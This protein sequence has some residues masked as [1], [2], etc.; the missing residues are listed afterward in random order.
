LEEG[1]PAWE[2][3]GVKVHSTG[4]VE[5]EDLAAVLAAFLG[6]ARKHDYVAINAY[7]PRNEAMSAALTE[8]RMKVLA[9]TGCATTVGFGPRFLHSTGQLHKGGPESGLFL[10]I[11][12]DPVEDVEIPGQGKAPG[13]GVTFG[14]LERCQ[15]L[16]DYEA[17][18]ARG[19]RILRVHL[20]SPKA[21]AKLILAL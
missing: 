5:G 21:V 1:K 18:A 16:G 8:L 11:T 20:P 17:L 12:A 7:L 13:T 4:K 9:R 6:A 3:D 10:Q 15:S 14:V 19:R 2:Q